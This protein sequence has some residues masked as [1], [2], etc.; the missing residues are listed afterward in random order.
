MILAFKSTVAGNNEVGFYHDKKESVLTVAV[1]QAFVWVRLFSFL[2][3][4]R[5]SVVIYSASKRSIVISIL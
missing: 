5:P 4:S 2:V 1:R 3:W